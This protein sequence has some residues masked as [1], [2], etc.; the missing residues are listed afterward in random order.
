MNPIGFIS[1]T[2]NELQ[3]I[4]LRAV[5]SAIDARP[6]DQKTTTRELDEL[7]TRAETARLLHVSLV[8]LRNYEKRG[9]LQPSRLGRRVLYSRAQVLACLEASG[10]V[11]R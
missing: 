1:I 9:I 10:R 3:S 7:L 11:R 5:R 4:V 8:T 6:V 2:E